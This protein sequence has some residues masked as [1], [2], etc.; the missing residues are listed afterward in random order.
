MSSSNSNAN[1][2]IDM[3]IGAS[4]KSKGKQVVPSESIDIDDENNIDIPDEDVPVTVNIAYNKPTNNN[5]LPVNMDKELYEKRKNDLFN[6]VKSVV[7]KSYAKSNYEKLIRDMI[8]VSLVNKGNETSEEISERFD[9]ELDT[10]FKQIY[11]G[12]DHDFN[13]YQKWKNDNPGSHDDDFEKNKYTKRKRIHAFVRMISQNLDLG[14]IRK[15]SNLP[16]GMD[17]YHDT[18]TQN[19]TRMQQTYALENIAPISG[20]DVRNS[21]VRRI[22]ENITPDNSIYTFLSQIS[23]LPGIKKYEDIIGLTNHQAMVLKSL[24]NIIFLGKM[25]SD[26]LRVNRYLQ[27]IIQRNRKGKTKVDSPDLY[28]IDSIGIQLSDDETE[29]PRKKSPKNKQNKKQSDDDELPDAP[30]EKRFK[31]VFSSQCNMMVY[32]VDGYSIFT[33]FINILRRSPEFMMKILRDYDFFRTS[34]VYAEFERSLSTFS[35]EMKTNPDFDDPY[36]PATNQQQPQQQLIQG[37]QRQYIH[38]FIR[39]GISSLQKAF[40]NQYDVDVTIESDQ[41]LPLESTHGIALS[42]TIGYNIMIKTNA[43]FYSLFP[44][45]DNIQFEAYLLSFKEAIDVNRE[46]RT[47]LEKVYNSVFTEDNDV[48]SCVKCS[49]STHK[50]EYHPKRNDN[51]SG[52][53]VWK[54]KLD[55]NKIGTSGNLKGG[56]VILIKAFNSSTNN[57]SKRLVFM[58]C[59]SP[60]LIVSKPPEKYIKRVG[61]STEVI[62]RTCFNK[63][64]NKSK[65]FVE[66]MGIDRSV[67][68]RSVELIHQQIDAEIQNKTADIQNGQNTKVTK[69]VRGEDGFPVFKDLKGKDA[70]KYLNSKTYRKNRFETEYEKQKKRMK[71]Q[72]KIKRNFVFPYTPQ[73]VFSAL[74]LNRCMFRAE[75]HSHDISSTSIVFKKHS[76]II[77]DSEE[78]NLQ[79]IYSVIKDFGEFVNVTDNTKDRNNTVMTFDQIVNLGDSNTDTIFNVGV[80]NT[81]G[82]NLLETN[83]RSLVDNSFFRGNMLLNHLF[84]ICSS[85]MMEF[86]FGVPSKAFCNSVEMI[87][88]YM[89]GVCF[90]ILSEA[91]AIKKYVDLKNQTSAAF[92]QQ[93]QGTNIDQNTIQIIQNFMNLDIQSFNSLKVV[94]D[95]VKEASRIIKD[96]PMTIMPQGCIN[97]DE[98]IIMRERIELLKSLLNDQYTPTCT[99]EE[100]QKTDDTDFSECVKLAKNSF[101]FDR[102]VRYEEFT[103]FD[104]K[105]VKLLLHLVGCKNKKTIKLLNEPLDRMSYSQNHPFQPINESIS[106]SFGITQIPQLQN[107]R[108][109]NQNTNANRRPPNR[110]TK[111]KGKQNASTTAAQ[112]KRSGKSQGNVGSVSDHQSMPIE[113]ISPKTQSVINA[114]N[115]KKQQSNTE[116]G[117]QYTNPDDIFESDQM[118]IKEQFEKLMSQYKLTPEETKELEKFIPPSDGESDNENPSQNNAIQTS[119]QNRNDEIFGKFA[120]LPH[121][122]GYLGEKLLKELQGLVSVHKPT[123]QELMDIYNKNKAFSKGSVLEKYFGQQKTNQSIQSS[124][125]NGSN[126]LDLQ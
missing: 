94:A 74:Q 45:V 99:F 107:L 86:F 57:T 85:D 104:R 67:L 70:I 20:I 122:E 72:D 111:K 61:T 38:T 28:N 32:N 59:T 14:T 125:V 4:E 13:E 26:E 98:I 27:E 96:D 71:K 5:L 80:N 30:I 49:N 114:R 51:S 116:S 43:F 95:Y 8:E 48:Y 87:H 76:R 103:L 102:C 66:K 1:T 108:N 11:G 2:I 52:R 39:S 17:L 47:P 121:Q 119:Q 126:L 22:P 115:S 33:T 12:Q 41:V 24:E 10:L 37:K 110:Q 90:L 106:R 124:A 56:H 91:T 92:I 79:S 101:S 118:N 82:F 69:K 9:E 75:F 77:I 25:D 53:T 89:I 78:P 31:G 84:R 73:K 117:I 109:R 34:N 36:F 105:F 54:I 123:N 29:E 62:D 63:F 19:L 40:L 23:F 58:K 97:N 81:R 88:T 44:N 64:K 100:I 113:N 15:K 7:T 6:I 112:K 83:T 42:R 93:N 21:V 60:F 50:F 35:Q 120:R 3:D 65:S 16:K 55:F 18:I 68:N 46:N